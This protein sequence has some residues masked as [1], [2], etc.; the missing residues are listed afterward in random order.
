MVSSMS[1]EVQKG[2]TIGNPN[3]P[4]RIVGRLSRLKQAV[5]RAE[6]DRKAALEAE[7]ASLEARVAALREAL[8]GADEPAVL[9]G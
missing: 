8:A 2:L 6:G 9:G 3:D 7:I 5:A 1:E 4:F